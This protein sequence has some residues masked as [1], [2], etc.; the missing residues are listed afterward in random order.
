MVIISAVHAATFWPFDAV[1]WKLTHAFVETKLII[2]HYI[3]TLLS[4]RKIVQEIAK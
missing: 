4:L 1:K 2:T 3:D